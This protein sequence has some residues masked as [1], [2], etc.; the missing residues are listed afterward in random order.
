MFSLAHGF[1]LLQFK[2]ETSLRIMLFIYFL[3][4]SL[5]RKIHFVLGPFFFLSALS[6]YGREKLQMVCA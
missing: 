5:G 6:K 1:I 3:L 4:I 2:I